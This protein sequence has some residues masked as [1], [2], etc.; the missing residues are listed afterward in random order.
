[1]E[2]SLALY[3]K[4]KNIAS[5]GEIPVTT[6]VHHALPPVPF[7][8]E[9]F[10][11]LRN[12][13]PHGVSDADHAKS[14]WRSKYNFAL[15]ANSPSTSLYGWKVDPENLLYN[16][17][18]TV[19]QEATLLDD[20]SLAAEYGI[21]EE[22]LRKYQ[23]LR[24]KKNELKK[25][26][27]ISTSDINSLKIELSDVIIEL[28]TIDKQP[29]IEKILLARERINDFTIKW[30]AAKNSMLSDTLT[31][32]QSRDSFYETTCVNDEFVKKGSSSWMSFKL[33]KDEI[34]KLIEQYRTETPQDILNIYGAFDKTLQSI[35]FEFCPVTII[36]GWFKP[37]LLKSGFWKL[38]NGKILSSGMMDYKGLIPCYTKRLLFVRKV[39]YFFAKNDTKYLLQ[40]V[41][42]SEHQVVVT[43]MEATTIKADTV[44]LNLQAL[45]RRQMENIKSGRLR[46]NDL[47]RGNMIKNEGIRSQNNAQEAFKPVAIAHDNVLRA[48]KETG[49]I[50]QQESMRR[51]IE[52]I[53][54]DEM[55]NSQCSR[56]VAIDNAIPKIVKKIPGLSNTISPQFIKL[57]REQ[58]ISK[59][60]QS[61]IEI[62][63]PKGYCLYGNITDNSGKPIDGVII[64]IW[65]VSTRSIRPVGTSFNDS[66]M[67]KRI[68]T[69]R[70]IR[71]KITSIDGRYRIV[72]LDA[73][74]YRI[75]F[76][77]IGYKAKRTTIR[78]GNDKFYDVSLQKISTLS[79]KIRDEQGNPVV[80]A[81]VDLKNNLLLDQET[82]Q[83]TSDANGVYQIENILDGNYKIT[84]RKENYLIAETDLIVNSTL[85]VEISM[86]KIHLITGIITENQIPLTG[87]VIFLQDTKSGDIIAEVYSDHK[88][89]YRIENVPS[90]E[91]LLTCKKEDYRTEEK[92]LM[93]KSDRIE[94]FEL[95]KGLSEFFLVGALCIRFPKLPDPH[96]EDVDISG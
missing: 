40:P 70:G 20:V 60:G 14:V 15:H 47:L 48:L 26:L 8:D 4:V 69:P 61:K 43:S 46:K 36:R 77:A 13:P 54:D 90:G 2:L 25:K 78:V 66:R 11:F 31:D 92:E 85:T 84:C 64:T 62:L 41:I 81:T 91:Y 3:Q 83:A 88:G 39:K 89:N 38:N 52:I 75:S 55:R 72:G 16:N 45:T 58:I 96:F 68:I 80:Q 87:A 93:I 49:F 19:L 79:G 7:G 17:Y 82:Y 71:S 57:N 21:T 18:Y 22:K 5:V 12:T 37:A 65:N 29:E 1:M 10:D 74:N 34:E 23:T 50:S 33:E 56:T 35:S 42:P 30:T 6:V 28:D 95:E 59:L 86:Q 63:H 51:Q 67:K 9:D 53:I 32:S 94:K 27:H 76:A 24:D 44:Q 73:G